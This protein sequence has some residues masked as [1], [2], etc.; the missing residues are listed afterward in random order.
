MKNMGMPGDYGGKEMKF[1][2]ILLYSYLSKVTTVDSETH[3]ETFDSIA[4]T[5]IAK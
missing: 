4:N 1:A 2:T 5:H 3:I